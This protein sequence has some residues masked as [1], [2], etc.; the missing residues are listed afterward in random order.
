M[1]F[2]GPHSFRH[3][4]RACRLKSHRTKTLTSRLPILLCFDPAHRQEMERTSGH[5]FVVASCP[6]HVLK[7]LDRLENRLVI[8]DRCPARLKCCRRPLAALQ[9]RLPGTVREMQLGVEPVK[10][11]GSR[12]I[13]PR[14]RLLSQRL[15]AA[16]KYFGPRPP[17]GVTLSELAGFFRMSP[18][19]LNRLFH[20]VSSLSPMRAFRRQRLLGAFH[21]L[22]T[23]T[24]SIEAVSE[25]LQ[26]ADRASFAKAFRR[27][28]G[29]YPSS[30]RRGR[31]IGVH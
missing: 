27:A 6:L 23:S 11:G 18:R 21:Q 25:D 10:A 15:G 26:Y 3:N 17:R 7:C 1:A 30:L 29:M 5:R 9:R 16:C 20:S 19:R 22:T 2:I 8:I 31:T 13:N 4:R 24:R 14:A 12:Q 28:F